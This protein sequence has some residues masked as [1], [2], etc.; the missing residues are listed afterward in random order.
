MRICA[1]CGGVRD[2]CERFCSACGT[3]ILAPAK[4]ASIGKFLLLSIVTLLGL[5]G[6][7]A[8][9]IHAIAPV[10]GA[11]VLPETPSPSVPVAHVNHSGDVVTV[12]ENSLCGS[13]PGALDEMYRWAVRGDKTEAA[14]VAINTHSTA[15][16]GGDTVKILE[17][18]F[19]HSKIRILRSERECWV[20]SEL[21]RAAR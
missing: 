7:L 9:F 12:Q 18:G 21:V 5:V 14:R 3:P 15:V 19:I 16:K 6:M 2:D 20:V 17:I 11:R 13:T 8:A 4:S 1:K 10:A